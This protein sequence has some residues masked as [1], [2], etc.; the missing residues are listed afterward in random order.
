MAKADAD[1][2]GTYVMLG[3]WERVWK[4]IVEKVNKVILF[5]Q[6]I[7][8]TVTPR[9]FFIHPQEQ[10]VL[11]HPEFFDDRYDSSLWGNAFEVYP[12]VC[13]RKA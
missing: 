4:E 6:R 12:E 5:L 11:G 9:S 1:M 8:C 7:N 10:H 13:F 2:I 3:K